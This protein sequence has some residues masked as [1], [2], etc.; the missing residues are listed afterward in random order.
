M[1]TPDLNSF[2]SLPTDFTLNDEANFLIRPYGNF[3]WYIAPVELLKEKGILGGGSGTYTPGVG[4]NI[5]ANEISL[6]LSNFTTTGS[7]KISVTD[8]LSAGDKII[9]FEVKNADASFNTKVTQTFSEITFIVTT[10]TSLSTIILNSTGVSMSGGDADYTSTMDITG[11][12]VNYSSTGPLGTISFVVGET[13]ITM[14]TIGASIDL[15]APVA[16]ISDG[17]L[18]L[19]TLDK[20]G[21][22]KSATLDSRGLVLNQ[23]GMGLRIKTGTNA[24]MGRATLVA[25]SVTVSNNLVTANSN[26]FPLRQISGGTPGGLGVS[27]RVVGTSFT[28]TSTSGTDTST[29]AWILFEPA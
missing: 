4:I 27:T 22:T 15:N 29:F 21:S 6:D 11:Q 1:A 24:L 19:T 7:S 8:E 12:G 17:A 14:A 20:N 26:I 9:D 5:T 10:D 28:V 18:L 2:K 13:A 25:G 3:D 23:V 16:T